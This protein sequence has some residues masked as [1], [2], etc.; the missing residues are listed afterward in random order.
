ME[1]GAKADQ[2]I[3]LSLNAKVYFK[4]LLNKYVKIFRIRLFFSITEN[5]ISLITPSS[6]I[7]SRLAF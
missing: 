3:L 1:R 2:I 4:K 5:R 7:K 6:E